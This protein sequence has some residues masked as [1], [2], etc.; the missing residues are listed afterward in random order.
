M[1]DQ[2]G[3]IALRYESH[4]F[5]SYSRAGTNRNT[6]PPLCFVKNVHVCCIDNVGVC[7]TC[8]RAVISK[9]APGME[10]RWGRGD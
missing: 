10:T 2:L 9:T 5:T 7:V 8:E 4:S 1:L 3:K 6:V